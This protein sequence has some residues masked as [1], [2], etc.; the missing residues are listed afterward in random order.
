MIKVSL[1]RKVNSSLSRGKELLMR[2]QKQI[3]KTLKE[4]GPEG[5][6]GFASDSILLWRVMQL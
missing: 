6:A 5:V 2:W 1:I 4:K 3:K